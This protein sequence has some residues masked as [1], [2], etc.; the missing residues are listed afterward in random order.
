VFRG[1]C[2]LYTTRII[3]VVQVYGLSVALQ[4]STS[5]ETARISLISVHVRVRGQRECSSFQV[6]VY[7]PS[8]PVARDYSQFYA[9]RCSNLPTA[10]L[11]KYK[12]PERV[13]LTLQ[14]TEYDTNNET[15]I[16]Q[17]LK[18][19]IPQ[20]SQCLP[21]SITSISPSLFARH[22]RLVSRHVRSC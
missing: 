9:R 20:M 4:V 7:L 18:V 21:R 22:C 2:D 5:D 15:Y 8:L 10:M 17:I 16:L 13:I 6:G 11:K 19:S 1:L 12:G 3:I 14:I